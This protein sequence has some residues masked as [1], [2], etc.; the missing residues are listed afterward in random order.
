MIFRETTQEDLEYVRQNP[1]EGA[2][3]NY[4]Y[5]QA[6]KNNCY[7][8]IFEDC[9]V[10]VGGLMVL[11]EGVGELWLM[12]TADCK[13]HGFYGI[14]ALSAI[15]DKMEELIENNNLRRAQATIRTDFPQA[16]K[17]IESFGFEREGLLKQYCPDKG[18]VY[19]YAKMIR[20]PN[21]H[22]R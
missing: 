5:M 10:G 20:R 1:F 7:T 4:P 17:M 19:M 2:V 13:K 18:N 21:G 12:L 11:W 14:I 3:K 6:P 8:V 15:K 22:E 9:I 16:I